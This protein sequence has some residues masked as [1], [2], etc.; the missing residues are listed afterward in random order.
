MDSEFSAGNFAIVIEAEVH[1]RLRALL[2]EQGE[3]QWPHHLTMAR[4]VARALRLGRS[5][6]IQ[7]GGA[8]AYRGDHR[9]SYLMSALI[10]P[11]PAVLVLPRSLHGRL[12]QADLPNLLHRLPM[13]KPV[14]S[15]QRWPSPDY[16]GLL[17]TDPDSWFQSKLEGQCHFPAAVA[18]LID[19]ADQVESWVRSHLTRSL[20]ETDWAALM[21]AYPS[22]QAS[23]R[24]LRVRL[25]HA[26]FQH[27]VNPY[28]C[29]LL[30]TPEQDLLQTLY[31]LLSD[32]PWQQDALPPNWRRFWSQLNQPDALTWVQVDR[33]QGRFTLHCAP[34]DIAPR[35]M[36][37]WDQ[38]PVVL[39]GA[40]VDLDSEAAAYRQQLGLGDLTCLKFAP[41]RHHD[42]IQLYLPDRLPMPNTRHFQA[43][44]LKEIRKL[45]QRPV[46]RQH[47][48]V[49]L[50]GDTP[51]KGQI[52]SILAAEFGSRVRV[53]ALTLA[54]NGILVCSWAYWQRHQLSLPCPHQL[55]ITTLPLPSLENPLVAGRVAHYK[56]HRQDWFRLYL[57]PAAIRQLQLAIAP[58]QVSQGHVA[59]L[60][61]RVSYRSY[62]RQILSA[63][64][65]AACSSYLD[66]SLDLPDILGDPPLS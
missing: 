21:L 28:D 46:A 39:M 23:I 32:T 5:A 36:P 30:D 9:L 50:V 45:L 66:A 2:R 42:S 14:Q 65:P 16:R 6:L 18:T 64:S 31:G 8:S 29:Y 11:E 43:A 59:L 53:E 33:Q 47:L 10:W 41:D 27:P 17:I 25:T 19:G 58:V 63:L 61:N 38:Q 49:V 44:A 7:T 1:Q 54:E 22:Q 56:R 55:I 57:L 34:A 48:T 35:L 12:L 37:I 3:P 24:D 13:V 40:A 15:G 20:D 26:S 60:D 62:G 52:G 4:L 51:L